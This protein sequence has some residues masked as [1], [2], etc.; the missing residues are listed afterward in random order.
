MSRFRLVAQNISSAYLHAVAT[1]GFTLVSI[2][3]ALRYLST[4]EFGLWVL[5]TQIIGY[6]TLVD[7]G[8]TMATMRVLIDRKDRP[9]DG[10]YGAVIKTASLVLTIQGMLIAALGFALGSWLPSIMEIPADH[11]GSFR[12]LMMGYG[13]LTGVLFPFRIFGTLLQAHHRLDLTNYFFMGSLPLNLAALWIGLH[14][15]LGI[16][17]LLLGQAAAGLFAWGGQA[18]TVVRLRFL[19]HP[20]AWG[21]FD[22]AVFKELLSF[23]SDLFLMSLGS[24]L[25]NA[26]QIVIISQTLG[27]QAAAVW[28]I[29]TKA[30]SLAQQFVWRLW[31]FSATA[32]AEMV[33]RDERARLQQRFREIFVVTASLGVLAGG[34]IAAC[35]ESLLAVWT[36][37]RI[38]WSGMNDFLMALLFFT[39]SITRLHVGLLAPTKKVRAMRFVLFLEGLFFV[40]AAV[41]VARFLG[42]PGIIAA[43]ILMN[44]LWTGIYGT[45][46]TAE[47]FSLSLREVALRWMI[48]S[49]RLALLFA[50][51]A[52]LCWWLFQPFPSL[53]RLILMAAVTGAIGSWSFWKIGLTPSVKAE[54]ILR[55]GN[56]RKRLRP[57][58]G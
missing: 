46:R 50:P 14:N 56:V 36:G 43:A 42:V 30:F 12:W 8:I 55:L 22:V 47:E 53:P 18:F 17:S 33:V 3:L 2:P 52:V 25:V 54:L 13:G 48:P 23:G 26:S 28:A 20:G 45:Y 51:I 37:S 38:A 4:E 24:Q 6:L 49:A 7:A 58:T 21:N 35:N 27:L 19:P 32:I 9:N 57:A 10:R 11:V 41:G 5:A 39:N 15:N 31:D 44:L 29:A 16:Y 34:I 1:V 40:A